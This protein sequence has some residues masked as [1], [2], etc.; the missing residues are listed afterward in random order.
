MLI[1][2]WIL[3]TLNGPSHRAP[4]NAPDTSAYQDFVIRQ[5][6]LEHA[7]TRERDFHRQSLVVISNTVMFSSLFPSFFANVN[8]TAREL[9]DHLIAA[10]KSAI[11]FLRGQIEDS[12]LRN[13]FLRSRG[14]LHIEQR[15]MAVETR[16]DPSQWKGNRVI[17][18]PFSRGA[19][20][21]LSAD[22]RPSPEDRSQ[23]PPRYGEDE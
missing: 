18:T 3:C 5:I 6:R 11:G 1:R 2:P 16:R 22:S 19:D 21:S 12:Y 23:Q 14:C 20:N 15:Q 4:G 10:Q 7:G 9:I 13:F 8:S 17:L